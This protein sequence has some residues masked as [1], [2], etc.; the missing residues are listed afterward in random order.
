M[1][2]EMD[3][4]GSASPPAPESALLQRAVDRSPV[5]MFRLSAEDVTPTWVSSNF[6]RVTGH[7]RDSF[8]GSAEYW[9]RQLHPE[10]R[11]R[12]L[13]AFREAGAE[14]AEYVEEEFRFEDP[15]GGFR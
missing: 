5:V 15:D 10:D 4:E 12:V 9:R 14:L 13:R 1:T 2:D 7:P 3:S 8:L 6:E 11:E